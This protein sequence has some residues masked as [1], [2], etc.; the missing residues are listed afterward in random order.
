MGALCLSRGRL[1][2]E[3]L[4][5]SCL[6]TSE[7][8]GQTNVTRHTI[9]PGMIAQ[10]HHCK[11]TRFFFPFHFLSSISVSSTCS[12]EENPSP[13]SPNRGGMSI[14]K[15]QGITLWLKV[16]DSY[17]CPREDSNSWVTVPS[18]GCSSYPCSLYCM[19]TKVCLDGFVGTCQK[20]LH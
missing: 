2:L 19:A 17:Y 13:F 4:M 10:L 1:Q 14:A 3:S 7:V 20:R 15:T 6:Q 11:A 5:K 16:Y 8:S 9:S 12:R 18:C